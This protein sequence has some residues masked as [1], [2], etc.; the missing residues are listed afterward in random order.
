[1]NIVLN[2]NILVSAAWYP[3]R[4]ATAILQAVFLKKF[5]VCYDWRILEEYERVMHYPKFSFEE[6]EISAV[7]DP[8]VKDGLSV[9]PDPLPHIPFERDESDRKFYEVAKYC[10]A[11]LI[12]GNL[13]H[14]PEDPEIL[15]PA[16]FCSRFI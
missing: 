3:G 4:N 14:Y 1:M 12:T 7:L 8:I 2:T 11:V 10:G 9:I 5:T 13:A 6:W 15:S 16:E